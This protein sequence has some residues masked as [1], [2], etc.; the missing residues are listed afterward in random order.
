[1]AGAVLIATAHGSG[2]IATR[3]AEALV[4]Q[5]L[6]E[7]V[8]N[9]ALS[10]V[11]L[12]YFASSLHVLTAAF[13]L[14]LAW[15]GQDR[16]ATLAFRVAAAV[17]TGWGLSTAGLLTWSGEVGLALLVA[18]VYGVP[19]GVLAGILLSKPVPDEGT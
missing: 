2:G 18:T 14:A 15:L 19:A 13:L 12:L 8:R 11:E 5:L 10:Y 3:M 7:D 1:M 4:K 17:V 9:S 6:P 16:A